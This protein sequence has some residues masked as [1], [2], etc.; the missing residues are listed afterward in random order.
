[1]FTGNPSQDI[2]KPAF[3]RKWP[4]KTKG[5]V[6]KSGNVMMFYNH[7]LCIFTSRKLETLWQ[8]HLKG[9]HWHFWSW[10]EILLALHNQSYQKNQENFD[11][12]FKFGYS[13]GKWALYMALKTYHNHSTLCRIRKL[14]NPCISFAVLNWYIFNLCLHYE[15]LSFLNVQDKGVVS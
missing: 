7:L 11:T 9:K 5:P 2:S 15:F 3:G 10:L 13:H 1:M 6:N 4:T 14:K 8:N 12:K